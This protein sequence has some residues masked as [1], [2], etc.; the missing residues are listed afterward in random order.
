MGS[1]FTTVPYFLIVIA[2]L[3]FGFS[4]FTLSIA[5]AGNGWRNWYHNSTILQPLGS[6]LLMLGYIFVAFIQITH[7]Q[8]ELILAILELGLILFTA[9]GAFFIF[10]AVWLRTQKENK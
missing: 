7:T 5:L 10:R 9:L 1:F 8:I 4:A 3:A 6:I 2:V